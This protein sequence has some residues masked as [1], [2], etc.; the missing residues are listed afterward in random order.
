MVVRQ[1]RMSSK[2]AAET[3]Y[4]LINGNAIM[5]LCPYLFTEL[6]QN[7]DLD[8]SLPL[9]LHREFEI[10]SLLLTA[11]RAYCTLLWTME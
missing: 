7:Y 2:A 6:G 11:Y 8:N 9:Y 10:K 5:N 4:K 1:Q 3:N